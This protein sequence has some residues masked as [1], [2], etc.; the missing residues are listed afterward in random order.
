[1]SEVKQ[2]NLRIPRS[3]KKMV[4]E[5]AIDHD[6]S[7]EHVGIQALITY[8]SS[9]LD[10]KQSMEFAKL[11]AALIDN[12]KNPDNPVKVKLD[13][14]SGLKLW[15]D[16]TRELEAQGLKKLLVEALGLGEE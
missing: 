11:R 6:L 12:I 7:Q 8:F 13:S 9:D 3:L 5:Y 10:P 2:F 16:L 1:M 14:I 4:A 15:K